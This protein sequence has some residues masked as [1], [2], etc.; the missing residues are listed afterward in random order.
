MYRVSIK[1]FFGKDDTKKV[2]AG[3]GAIGHRIT[4]KDQ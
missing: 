1:S 4:Q 2:V 3:N